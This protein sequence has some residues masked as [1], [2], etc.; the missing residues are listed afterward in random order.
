M[1]PKNKKDLR[2]KIGDIIAEYC[3]ENDDMDFTIDVKVIAENGWVEA[4][5]ITE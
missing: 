1:K 5:E 4:I 3:Y 2:G